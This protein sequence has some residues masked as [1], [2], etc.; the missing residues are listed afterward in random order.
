[1]SE[2]TKKILALGVILLI[3]G[4][5]TWHALW[6]HSLNQKNS[7]EQPQS[8]APINAPVA[9]VSEMETASNPGPL[10][11]VYLPSSKEIEESIEDQ[12]QKQKAAEELVAA[13]KKKAKKVLAIVAAESALPEIPEENS[14]NT[15]ASLSPEGRA[16]RNNEL[17]EG[18]KAG[19]YFPH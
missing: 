3:L 15:P 7:V 17:K 18:I 2:D 9:E 19:R 14:E 5:V 11:I 4:I 1:M 8:L 16:E 6:M 10:P 13:R 12:Q